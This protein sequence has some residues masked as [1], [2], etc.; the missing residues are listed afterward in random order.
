MHRAMIVTIV[1]AVVLLALVLAPWATMVRMPGQS[2]SGPFAPLSAEEEQSRQRLERD[3]RHLTTRVGERNFRRMAALDSAA[4]YIGARFAAAG[5]RVTPQRFDIEGQ[6]F[7]NVEVSVRGQRLP[8]EIVV[9]GG[10]YDSVVGTVGADDN[11]SGTAAVLEL[12]R[13]LRDAKLDRTVRF[14]AF[15][16]E[17]PPFFLTEGMGSRVYAR[18]A[19]E[20]GDRIVAMLSLETIGY[21]SDKAGS[22]RYPPP[23]N[24]AYPDRGDFIG[25]VGNVDS[26]ALVR[27][28]IGAFR[29]H[30]NFP[31]EGVAA[32]SKIPGI[33]WSDHSSFWREGWPAIM[34]TDTAPFRNPAYHTES[35]TPDRIDYARMARVTRGIAE[36]VKELAGSA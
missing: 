35:D 7:R 21:Y 4:D 24:L 18:E 20:R 16:N 19:A 36:V 32:P 1:I 25:F 28:A 27:R 17:E 2:F 5:Y 13:L 34:I 23:I 30:A 22:Q 12:A 29:R 9:I 26:R 33:Y 31:S 15:T 6:S 10:H 3:V 14:V 11:A 8:D